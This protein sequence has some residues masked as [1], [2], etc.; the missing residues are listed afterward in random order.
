MNSSNTYTTG[1]LES[2]LP[3][4]PEFMMT[5]GVEVDANSSMGGM[6]SPSTLSDP[7]GWSFPL[8]FYREGF[9]GSVSNEEAE[10]MEERIDLFKKRFDDDLARRNK[11]LFGE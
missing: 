3:L 9:I 10:R 5:I 6:W 1:A 8:P 7:L 11:V 4:Y 2:G